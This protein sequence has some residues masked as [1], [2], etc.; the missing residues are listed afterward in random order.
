[1]E[2]WE[3]ACEEWDEEG[4]ELLTGPH[5][6]VLHTH[7]CPHLIVTYNHTLQVRAQPTKRG[8][9]QRDWEQ[10]GSEDDRA[11]EYQLKTHQCAHLSPSPSTDPPS[12]PFPSSRPPRCIAYGSACVSY[13][14]PPRCPRPLPPPRPPCPSSPP[15]PRP[16]TPP[17]RLVS[18]TLPLCWVSRPPPMASPAYWPHAPP[19][20]APPP[21]PP[22]RAF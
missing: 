8:G 14:L 4:P 16:P 13:A 5:E 12:H 2:S 11:R 3:E 17:P 18:S 22:T 6:T 20:T 21:P 10:D 7:P 19:A 1:V 9:R 15:P